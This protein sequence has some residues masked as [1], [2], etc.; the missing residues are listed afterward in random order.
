MLVVDSLRVDHLEAAGYDRETM[1]NLTR[2]LERG[3]WFEQAFSPAPD[4]IP[5]HAALLTGC[6]PRVI[7]QPV[8][9]DLAFLS[10]SR[11]WRVP[12]ETPSLAAEF[13]A[14]GFRTA[15]F[16]DHPWLSA[17]Y[18]IDRGFLEFDSF[19]G[20]K[21]LDRHDFGASGMGRSFYL[22][23]A[24]LERDA[25]WFA[26]LTINDLERGLRVQNGTWDTFFEPRPE[27]DEVPP[28]IR[29]QRAFFGIPSHLGVEPG[30]TLGELE[31]RY[32][33]LLRQL[34]TK[35]GRLFAQ[36]EA[37]G[38][39]AETTVA[40]VGSYGIGFGEAGLYL[41][42]GTLADVDLHVP[43]ILVPGASLAAPRGVRAPHV[44]ST[45]D[46]MPTLLELYGLPLPEGMHGVSQLSALGA[47]DPPARELAFSSG[48][49][50]GGFAVHD[51]R[52]SLQWTAPAVVGDRAL[53]T[54]WYGVPQAPE[55]R[56][57]VY[58]R[59]RAVDSSP[60]DRAPS[61]RDPERTTALLEAGQD[62]RTWIERARFALH[63]PPWLEEPVSPE[64]LT[65][66][67][68]RGLIPE[69]AQPP[70]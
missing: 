30:Q 68:R 35:L 25:D 66:L 69:S 10:L 49:L 22:W 52:Y 59:D 27:L 23:L 28:M 45:I 58:L 9:E 8:P 32:D 56:H 29:A 3:V 26:Y 67:T 12:D 39:L 11:M 57:R 41:D 14:Q 53:L 38:R 17:H 50:C 15:A 70:N 61:S 60:G 21:P 1:P 20:G 43:W 37:K 46:L 16:V 62:W 42:H 2:L 7:R 31:A 24:S 6:D 44:A 48:G 13:L 18:G 47:D 54:S 33:G 63:D 65:E 4:Q 64:E 34:D 40:V 5:A 51:E 36:L 55:R 19:S